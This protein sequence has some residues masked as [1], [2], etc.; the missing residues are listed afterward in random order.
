MGEHVG[1]L[2]AVPVVL[3]RNARE[4]HDRIWRAGRNK[5]A[6]RKLSAAE[7]QL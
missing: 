5:G 7:E 1:D 3:Q 2:A 6:E 4:I